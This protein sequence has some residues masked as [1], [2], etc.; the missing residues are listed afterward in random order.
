MNQ[1]LEEIAKPK[2]EPLIWQE[3]ISKY[4]RSQVE[5]PDSKKH[6][7][8]LYD[9]HGNYHTITQKREIVKR[10]MDAGKDYAEWYAAPVWDLARELGLIE[11]C[12]VEGRQY[13]ERYTE[14]VNT[15][16]P[17]LAP[18]VDKALISET[19]PSWNLALLQNSRQQSIAT[20]EAFDSVM[21]AHYFYRMVATLA[22]VTTIAIIVAIPLMLV[23]IL[24]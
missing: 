19:E 16:K 22:G 14:T 11:Q 17:V 20:K 6:V 23:W 9:P 13:Q 8:L 10:F 15:C 1:V 5:Y 12:E 21:A 7:G 4:E 24:R 18:S 3:C 2:D